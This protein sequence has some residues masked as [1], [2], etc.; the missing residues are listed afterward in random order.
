M[1]VLITGGHG[2]V[3]R[4]LAHHLTE[5][6]DEVIAT[7]H[8]GDK[9]SRDENHFM[10]LPRTS[11]AISLDICDVG[12]VNSVMELLRP[13][14]VYHLAAITFVPDGEKN[15]GTVFAVNAHGTFNLLEAVK[16]HCSKS[17]FLYVS[18]A[19]VYGDPRPGTLPLVETAELRPI[20]AYGLSKAS[21]DLAVYQYAYRE[22]L[23]AVRARPFPHTGPGQDDK[24]ALSSFARQ[25]VEIRLGMREPVI[26]VG[27]LEARRDYSDVKDIVRG[28][29]EALLNGK[30]GAAYNFCSGKSWA[31]SEL[32]QKLIEMAEVEVEIRVDQSRFRSVD[33]ADLCGS[34]EAARRD[35]G[36]KP[37][38][39]I[40]S[41]LQSLLDYWQE[42]LS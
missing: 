17:P 26:E 8:P 28:Y 41:T 29:R 37:R 42:Q 33:I 30:R 3:G 16:K 4:Y 31:I 40:D 5:C 13:E 14:A 23:Q 18:S 21:A 22:R 19:E 35:F 38:I 1:R 2:F 11:Q 34:Y 39:E 15:L 9:Q 6:G 27:N 12:M 36:W 10:P 32:L 24:F 7:Y 25:L 20:S